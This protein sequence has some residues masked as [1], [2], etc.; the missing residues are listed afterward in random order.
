MVEIR[1]AKTQQCNDNEESNHSSGV[2]SNTNPVKQQ[3]D[4]SNASSFDSVA[5]KLKEVMEIVLEYGFPIAWNSRAD[6]SLFVFRKQSC[7][8][9]LLV[10]V[11]DILLTEPVKESV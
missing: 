11:D 3:V 10:Y 5:S 9:L 8:V 4:V 1:V 2:I 7:V 6:T